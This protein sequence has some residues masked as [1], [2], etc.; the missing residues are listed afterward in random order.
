MATASCFGARERPPFDA[1]IDPALMSFVE[2]FS[3][4]SF[5]VCRCEEDFI[6][7]RGD[8]IFEEE[9]LAL[10]LEDLLDFESSETDLFLRGWPYGS[11]FERSLL[12]SVVLL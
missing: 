1:K 5:A 7:F 12:G 6:L 11:L 2:F 3:L 10:S 8:A 9:S 4:N